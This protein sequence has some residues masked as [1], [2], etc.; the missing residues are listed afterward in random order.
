VNPARFF[1][2]EAN[3]NLLGSTEPRQLARAAIDG[4]QFSFEVETIAI[5]GW[6]S[7]ILLTMHRERRRL[8]KDLI[9]NRTRIG[10]LSKLRLVGIM[11][12]ENGSCGRCL[13]EHTL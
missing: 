4:S 8:W 11:V 6:R 10:I 1:A 2:D 5:A 9:E 3:L 7:N 13:W 12:R